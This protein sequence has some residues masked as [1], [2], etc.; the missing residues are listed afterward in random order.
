MIW[1]WLGSLISGPII[2]AAINAY[3]AKLAAGNESE[4]LAAD[5]AAKELMLETHAR[6]L[7]TQVLISEQG[8]WYTAL[9]R[10]LFAYAIVIYVWKVVVWDKVFG[11]GI[12]DPLTGAVGDWAGLIMVAYFGGRSVE[13]IA[14]IFKRR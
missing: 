5:L 10:P 2:G 1:S 7:S 13:K 8:R 4:R 11:L 3:K 9:P 6:E 14:Q 12:T